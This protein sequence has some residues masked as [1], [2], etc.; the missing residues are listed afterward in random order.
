M[1]RIT[2]ST[3]SNAPEP[4]RITFDGAAQGGREIFLFSERLLLK[5]KVVPM[6]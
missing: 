4:S 5:Q 6:R 2:T 3:G 1:L